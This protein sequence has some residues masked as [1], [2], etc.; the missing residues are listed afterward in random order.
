MTR[1]KHA[2]SPFRYGDRFRQ[3]V[4]RCLWLVVS[5]MLT[6]S[7]VTWA[8]AEKTLKVAEASETSSWVRSPAG[9]LARSRS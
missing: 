6:S 8:D 2:P 5:I 3:P 7:N 9:R 4:F 1:L